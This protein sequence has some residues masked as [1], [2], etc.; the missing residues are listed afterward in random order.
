M[1]TDLTTRA[2]AVPGCDTPKAA[3]AAP[4][5]G[6][7]RALSVAGMRALSVVAGLGY[8]KYYT[9]E[10]SVQEVGAFFY[11]GTLSYILNA[12]VFVP[13]DSYM[14]ARLSDMD[15]LPWRS[16]R[17]L[18]AVTL[19]VALCVCVA[20]S[21][22]F[23]GMGL[24]SAQD[25]PLLYSLAAMLYLCTSVRNLL[26]IRGQATFASSM[27][28][29]ESVSRLLA[30]M[31]AVWVVGASARTLLSSSIAALAVE[32]VLLLRQARTTLPLSPQ[33]VVLDHPKQIWKTTSALSGGAASNTVQL[34]AYRVLFPAA[35]HAGTVAML[36]VPSNIGAVG[37]SACA[38]VFSQL[39][40]PRLYQTRGASIRQYVAWGTAMAVVVLAFALPMSGFLVHHLTRAEYMAY[41][42]A[43]GVGVVL[44]A[45]NMLIGA[46]S[47][48]LTLHGRVGAMF[49]F[50]LVG[51]AVSLAGCLALIMNAPDSP[52]LIG[53]VIAGS[54]LLVTPA[55]AFYV[56]RLQRQHA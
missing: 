41:A 7:A 27:I 24:L 34:Q 35:G 40:L 13:V 38:Q 52:M 42:P 15:V 43:V 49:R 12:L 6:A 29:L 20:L 45:C 1:R 53:L 56:Y 32:L 23:I 11:L 50:Q 54:Q 2:D 48:Y 14:Q 16:I 25:V 39:F 4:R 8:V 5:L 3:P 9:N 17:R 30:F 26:N 36:G 46:F 37:M 55:L 31:L 19:L 28:V 47:V 44:E 10:L 51:A 33:E 22:P 21:L 18:M